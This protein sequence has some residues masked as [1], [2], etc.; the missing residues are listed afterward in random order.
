[1]SKKDKRDA[2]RSAIGE[3]S[4]EN[5]DQIDLEVRAQNLKY[6]LEKARKSNT[7]LRKAVR[8]EQQALQTLLQ[9]EKVK[10]IPKIK[11]PK[12]LT[13]KPI[14][15]AVA[16]FGDAHIE[17]QVLAARVNDLNF[18]NL[19]EAKLRV[20]AFFTRLVLKL[21]H[22]QKQWHIDNLVLFFLGDYI[23][24]YI[25]EE[26]VINNFLTP[27]EATFYALELLMSG[28]DYLLEH[29][30]VEKIIVP[31]NYGNHGRNV[32]WRPHSTKAK[33]S[34]EWLLY[35]MLQLM[36]K[37]QGV[38]RLEFNIADGTLIFQDIGNFRIRA[39]HGDTFNYRGGLGG[40]TIPMYTA[41][42]LS[43]S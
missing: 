37:K 36:Y 35:N 23:T 17:E 18:Y 2:F 19:E 29:A 32:K 13:N 12:S 8:N 39:N 41:I 20:E 42:S 38:D 22:E 7:A 26:F 40:V 33:M 5:V 6:E 15:T 31:C 43:S 11:I 34:Y 24:G 10:K 27:T 25:H 9:L 4:P 16:L 14:A 3:D 1:M 28:L 30:P 21:E